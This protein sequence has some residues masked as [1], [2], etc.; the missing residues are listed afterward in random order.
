MLK[1]ERKLAIFG[2]GFS[3]PSSRSNIETICKEDHEA[4]CL[5]TEY[6]ELQKQK[7]LTTEQQ[8]RKRQIASILQQKIAAMNARKEEERKKQEEI[9]RMELSG[10]QLTLFPTWLKSS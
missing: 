9:A 8:K 5:Y 6:Y 4:S 7:V 3:L 1:K 2:L 10:T